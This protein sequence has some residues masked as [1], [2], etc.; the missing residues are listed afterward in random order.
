MDDPS[1]EILKITAAI[2]P[3][4]ESWP[5]PDNNKF[6]IAGDKPTMDSVGLHWSALGHTVDDAR[7]RTLKACGAMAAVDEDPKLS[8]Q[9]KAAE[10]A[11]IAEAAL[12]SLRKSTN[13]DKARTAAAKVTQQCAAKVAEVVKP[14]ETPH[15]ASVHAQIRDRLSAMTDGR[16]SFLEKNATDP[17]IASAILTAPAFL[18][19]LSDPEL[20]L[21][22]HR[23]ELQAVGFETLEARDET[24]RALADA[25]KGFRN[26]VAEIREAAGLPK[27]S[28]GAMDPIAYACGYALWN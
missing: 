22:K 25:E 18:S 11:S 28:N 9:G 3:S 13:L 6:S 20:A 12:T 19:G 8:H 5:V 21:V 1:F 16:M 14:A 27:S 7:E 2:C 17:V 4:R 15:E 10:K 24:V 26:A 23:V